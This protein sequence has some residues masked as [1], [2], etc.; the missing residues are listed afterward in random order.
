MSPPEPTPGSAAPQNTQANTPEADPRLPILRAQLAGLLATLHL[1]HALNGSGERIDL[2][3]LDDQ[4]G[5]LC[6]SALDLPPAAGR[7]LRSDIVLLGL[8]ISELSSAL[9]AQP[10]G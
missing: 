2:T 10:P 6:A 9:R 7:T 5:R 4:V 1:A 8:K 3:G